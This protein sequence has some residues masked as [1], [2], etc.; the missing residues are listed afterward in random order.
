M[1][2]RNIHLPGG[3]CAA[4]CSALLGTPSGDT[5]P[6]ALLCRSTD[7]HPA[8]RSLLLPAP[9]SVTFSLSALKSWWRSPFGG[10]RRWSTRWSGT[11]STTASPSAT[12]RCGTEKLDLAAVVSIAPFCNASRKN[13][14]STQRRSALLRILPPMAVAICTK[15]FRRRYAGQPALCID[16]E[17][18]S[19]AC[20]SSHVG[21]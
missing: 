18:V 12:W 1:Y 20:N 8:N 10:G 17:C 3:L 11:A 13:R 9:R 6:L 15:R 14:H 4:P 2:S 19:F 21:Y 16:H 7:N 5:T